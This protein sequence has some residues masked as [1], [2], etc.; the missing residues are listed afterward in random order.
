[1]LLDE[2]CRGHEDTYSMSAEPFV[3]LRKDGIAGR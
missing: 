2:T 3:V 1:M